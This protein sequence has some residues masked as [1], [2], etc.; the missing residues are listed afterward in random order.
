MESLKDF[1][2]VNLK[3]LNDFAKYEEIRTQDIA[4]LVA[5]NMG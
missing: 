4:E 2:K 1:S 5:K 3:N